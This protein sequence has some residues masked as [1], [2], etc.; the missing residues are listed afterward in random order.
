MF[1]ESWLDPFVEFRFPRIGHTR[2]NGIDLELRQAIEPW[3]VLGEEATG[4][5]TARYVD[6]S[7]ERIQVRVR[8]LDPERY[9]V[10]C[11]GVP[12]PLTAT[13]MPGEYY[14]GVR[15]KAW[16]PW[17]ALHPSIG[18]QAPLHVDIVDTV[19]AVSLGG[20][21]YHVVHPGGL[22]YSHPPINANEAETRRASR[23]EPRGFTAGLLDIA[24]MQERGRRAASSEYPHLLDLRRA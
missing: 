13:E 11:N 20:A 2:I 6:S 19:S 7:I 9:L 10:T 16:A 24:A 3:H 1:E 23:F 14:A 5:G 17:S 22:S 8:G 18:V 15:Y 12:V 21:T 4:T